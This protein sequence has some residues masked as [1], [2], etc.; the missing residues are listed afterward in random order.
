M[1]KQKNSIGIDV[2]FQA[3]PGCYLL[4]RPD[5]EFTILDANDAYLKTTGTTPE[6]I[7]QPLF[8]IFPDN[9]SDPSANGVKNLT[10]SLNKVIRTKK[11]DRISAHRFD[12]RICDTQT[13]GIRYWSCVNIPVLDDEGNLQCIIHSVVDVTDREILRQHLRMRDRHTQQQISDAIS[14]TREL[15]CMEISRELHDNINQLLVTSSLY[16]GRALHGRQQKK[17]LLETGYELLEKAIAEIR[18]IST[19]LLHN[20]VEEHN[21]TGA[22][23]NLL[24][25]VSS[26]GT[27]NTHKEM[28]IPD[29]CRLDAKLK[30]MLFRIIQEAVANALKHS[31]AKNLFLGLSMKSDMLSLVIRDDG[32]GFATEQKNS[33]MGF[34]N[35]KSRVALMDGQL[36]IWSRPGKGVEMT[37]QVPV[38]TAA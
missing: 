30:V 33:G 28:N 17:E 29:E 24:C 4:L 10:A 9:P 13:F 14:T 21:L 23:N 11:K 27:I 12:T 5:P 7:G 31:E 37:V 3:L 20:N 36:R 38:Q 22:I 35:I 19:T 32:K 34:R 16:I 25:Q 18:N 8:R 15:Q 1:M 6:I 26:F 2:L